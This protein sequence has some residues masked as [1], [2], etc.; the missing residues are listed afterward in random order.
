MEQRNGKNSLYIPSNIKTRTEFFKGFGTSEL[1][2]T[3]IMT[4]IVGGL[5]YLLYQRNDNIIMLVVSIMVSAGVGVA[6]FSKDERN[7]SMVDTLMH[8][9]RFARQQKKYPYHFCKE[10]WYV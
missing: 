4:A 8:M 6:I 2:R 7:Q 1:K 5:F 10:D 3:A 9:L